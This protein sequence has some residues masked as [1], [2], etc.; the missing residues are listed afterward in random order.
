MYKVNMLPY[1]LRELLRG[2]NPAIVAVYSGGT[3]GGAGSYEVGEAVVEKAISLIRE[4]RER[5]ERGW[6]PVANDAPEDLLLVESPG[7]LE[8]AIFGALGLP[9]TRQQAWRV[10][11][12]IYVPG[13]EEF[14]ALEDIDAEAAYRK[15]KEVSLAVR[16]AL[17]K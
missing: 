14:H 7:S 9:E 5:G 16:A 2:A 6:L 11:Q 3:G 13:V 8:H 12:K 4:A 10:Y 1:A 15:M 17:A